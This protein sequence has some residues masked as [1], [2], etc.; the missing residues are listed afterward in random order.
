M[1]RATLACAAAML[2]LLSG[3]GD[4][5]DDKA[6]SEPSSQAATEPSSQAATEPGTE[7]LGD[8]PVDVVR[9][10]LGALDAGDAA[11]F[12]GLQ[13]EK[14]TK[15]SIADAIED[16]TIRKGSNCADMVRE[17]VKANRSD[18]VDSGDATLKEVSNDGTKA[19]VK[20]SYE[21]PMYSPYTLVL[22][23][24]DGQWLLDSE[25]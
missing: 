13:T 19:A 18:D 20:V 15:S 17:F 3:C 24:V 10:Y 12:C 2:V 21:D 8:E 25:R 23:K 6:T 5:G 7:A 14:Y 22:V 11:T 4:S 16:D 1:T 9:T